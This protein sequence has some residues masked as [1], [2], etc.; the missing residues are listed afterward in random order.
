MEQRGYTV[1]KSSASLGCFDLWC[2]GLTDIVLIQVKSG[3][4]VPS[5]EEKKA[6]VEMQVPSIARKEWWTYKKHARQPIIKTLIDGVWTTMP[7]EITGT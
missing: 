4:A 1:C 5:K 7:T 3:K 2:I 6:M